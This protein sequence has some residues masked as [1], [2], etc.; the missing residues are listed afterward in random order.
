MDGYHCSY[1]FDTDDDTL[2]VEYEFETKPGET[3]KF[4]FTLDKKSVS[5]RG[6]IDAFQVKPSMP[7][8]LPY[9]FHFKHRYGGSVTVRLWFQATP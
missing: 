5:P 4:A 9:R 3:Q 1:Q 8:D 7:K 6:D 2:D